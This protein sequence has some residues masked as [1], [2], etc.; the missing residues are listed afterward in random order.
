[1]RT[2]EGEHVSFVHG[3]C[4]GSFTVVLGAMVVRSALNQTPPN[5]DS[6]FF[7][8]AMN[9][10]PR[11][12]VHPQGPKVVLRIAR[13]FGQRQRLCDCEALRFQPRD[14]RMQKGGGNT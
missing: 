14:G 5:I 6:A 10:K 13:R 2:N 3:D 8:G 9:L 7:V 11:R 1:M 12:K 4:L